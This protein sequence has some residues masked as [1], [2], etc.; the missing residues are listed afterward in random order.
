MP[1]SAPTLC[2]SQ[3]HQLV[4]TVSVSAGMNTGVDSQPNTRHYR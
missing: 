3:L 4:H 1:E 2:A